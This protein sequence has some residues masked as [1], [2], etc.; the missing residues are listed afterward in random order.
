MVEG[1]NGQLRGISVT[2][3]QDSNGRTTGYSSVETIYGRCSITTVERTYD[4]AGHSTSR[5][6]SG[7][8]FCGSRRSCDI[9]PAEGASLGGPIGPTVGDAIGL[10]DL[11][12][13]R[14]HANGEA[15]SGGSNFMT[16]RT[17]AV[18]VRPASPDGTTRGTRRVAPIDL[19]QPEG[20]GIN[21]IGGGDRPD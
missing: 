14:Q 13:L 6:V 10:T 8:I 12:L 18:Q 21:V 17:N 7:D 4:R 9:N 5:T 20:R 15:P 11:D 16:R 3:H 1:E 19:L 2:Q